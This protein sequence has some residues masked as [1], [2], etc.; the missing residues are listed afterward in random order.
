M[1]LK[2]KFSILKEMV[3]EISLSNLKNK[4]VDIF[5]YKIGGDAKKERIYYS[6]KVSNLSLQHVFIEMLSLQRQHF[7]QT[8]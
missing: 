7:G 2:F 6:N 8:F 1:D 5:H 3:P 4:M